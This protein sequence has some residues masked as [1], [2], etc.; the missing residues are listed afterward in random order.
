MT[1]P[2]PHG[3]ACYSEDQRLLAFGFDEEDCLQKT[4]DPGGGIAFEHDERIDD[5]RAALKEQNPTW[6]IRPVM[7]VPPEL[8]EWVER[9][10]PLLHSY[11]EDEGDNVLSDQL[12][13]ELAEIEKEMK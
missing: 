2:K 1:P 12:L 3:W 6:Q 13:A 5:L 4:I 9:V 10:K 8:L 7:L 11:F